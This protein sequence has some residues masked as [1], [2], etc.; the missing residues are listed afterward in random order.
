VAAEF[1]KVFNMK[2][3]D[4]NATPVWQMVPVG[5]DRYIALRDGAGLTV[6][7]S[8]P[9]VMTVTEITHA[10]IPAGG[11][12]MPLQPG[13]RIF[14]LTGVTKG[15][16]RMQAKNGAALTVE[17]EA[18]TKNQKNVLLS[19]NFL[20][21]SAGHHT[22]RVPASA[23]HW[24]T[25][26]NYIYNGQANVKATLRNTRSVAAAVDLGPQVMWAADATSEWGT[27]TALG[28]AGADLNYFLVW[29][30]EQDATPT[31]DNTDAG[32]LGGNCIFE[33][34]AGNAVGTTMAHEMGHFLGVGDRYAAAQKPDLMY[35][36]TDRRGYNLTKSDVN[37]MNP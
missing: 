3:F 31:I 29:E 37:T 14:K 5:G 12:R 10:L 33:D 34:N 24:V 36:I 6:T 9:A 15:N 11:E 22:R 35:G 25:Q 26:I 18:D 7:S 13:D 30:Y 1:H 27:V 19:F 23:A 32:T 4:K 16:A 2:G 21:D 8:A 28:D 20:R 17:L